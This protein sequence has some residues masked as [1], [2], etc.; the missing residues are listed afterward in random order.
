MKPTDKSGSINMGT[1]GKTRPTST[2]GIA[3]PLA[4]K[5]EVKERNS[6]PVP[7][8]VGRNSVDIDVPALRH[9]VDTVKDKLKP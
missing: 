9:L 8:R 5:D 7:T 1:D 2:Q 6:S 4:N 3:S